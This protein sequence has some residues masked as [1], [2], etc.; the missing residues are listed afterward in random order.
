MREFLGELDDNLCEQCEE[1]TA[2]IDE[3]ILREVDQ[4]IEEDQ[5]MEAQ[6]KIEDLPD[7]PTEINIDEIPLSLDVEEKE[8]IVEE[9]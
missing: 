2:A 3:S 4:S 6:K 1:D 8:C 5:K 7:V 9:E